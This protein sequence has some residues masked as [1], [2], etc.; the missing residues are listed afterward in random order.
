MANQ[1]TERFARVVDV[2]HKAKDKR[3]ARLKETDVTHAAVA[4]RVVV[5]LAHA[6]E[7]RVPDGAAHRV[8]N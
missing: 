8:S 6:E 5:R 7:L 4:I 3:T 2:A 1:L